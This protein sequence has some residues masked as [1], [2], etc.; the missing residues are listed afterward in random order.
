LIV[1]RWNPAEASFV[2]G[3]KWS[4]DGLI[5]A[6]VQDS[7][8]NEVLMMAWM[9]RESL[10]RTLEQGE[11]HFYSRSRQ[12]LWHKGGSSGHIQSVESIHVDCD[13]DVL[14]IK[15]RQRG[16]ACHEGY[17]TCFARQ[18]DSAGRLI[19]TEEPVFDPASVYPASDG[20]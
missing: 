12:A 17:R 4:P 20:T 3:L 8:S 13:G 19:V 1:V 7:A 14:L 16:G 5:P 6:I 18:V 15:V 2:S 11:T 9:N 10:R